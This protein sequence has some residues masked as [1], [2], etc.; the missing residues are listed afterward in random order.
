MPVSILAWGDWVLPVMQGVHVTSAHLVSLIGA[1]SALTPMSGTP[2]SLLVFSTH[3][4]LTILCPFRTWRIPAGAWAA[5]QEVPPFLQAVVAAES[6]WIPQPGSRSSS[7]TP[8]ATRPA[9]DTRT[10]SRL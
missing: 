2:D 8:P 3:R 5:A 9:L 6:A 1:H 10:I 7:S 4:V